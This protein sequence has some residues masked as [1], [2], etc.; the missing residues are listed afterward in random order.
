MP[1]KGNPTN[2]IHATISRIKCDSAYL[3]IFRPDLEH[4]F[5]EKKI[6]H[7]LVLMTFCYCFLKCFKCSTF[8]ISKTNVWSITPVTYIREN[9]IN[10]F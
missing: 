10:R 3:R 5:M 4:S 6:A 9:F 2:Y 1:K 8:R 7:F